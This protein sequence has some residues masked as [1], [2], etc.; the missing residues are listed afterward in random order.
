MPPDQKKGKVKKKKVDKGL[1]YIRTLLSLE[2]GDPV[3]SSRG[4]TAQLDRNI[5]LISS[6]IKWSRM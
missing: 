5:S 4:I 6:A 2:L 3:V 1:T